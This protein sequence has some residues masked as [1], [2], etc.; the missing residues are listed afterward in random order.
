MCYGSSDGLSIENMNIEGDE[1]AIEL[2]K[3][4]ARY[5]MYKAKYTNCTVV[6]GNLEIVS[7]IMAGNTTFDLDFLRDIR[8]V[9][10]RT[11]LLNYRQF[12]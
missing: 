9:M 4:R 11:A 10:S 7:L 5:E 1:D 6:N 8:E 3:A 2:D 12:I